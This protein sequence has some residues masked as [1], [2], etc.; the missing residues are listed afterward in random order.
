MLNIYVPQNT[1]E[2]YLMQGALE[3][4]G[5]FC[6]IHGEY[7]QGAAGLLPVNNNIMLRVREEDAEAARELIAQYE[8]GELS[9]E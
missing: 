8:R 1:I 5:I 9:A 2:A 3:A 4:A 6:E 7:L